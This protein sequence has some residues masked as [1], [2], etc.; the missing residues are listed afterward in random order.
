VASKSLRQQQLLPAPSG[1]VVLARRDG[2]V[3]LTSPDADASDPPKRRVTCMPQDLKERVT[4]MCRHQYP[5]LGEVVPT[6]A[7][8]G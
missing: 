5:S 4:K 1:G 7:G 2:E 6:T 3:N 8:D